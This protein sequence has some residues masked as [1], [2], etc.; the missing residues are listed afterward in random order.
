MLWPRSMLCLEM[1]QICIWSWQLRRHNSRYPIWSI[2]WHKQPSGWCMVFTLLVSANYFHNFP[3][4]IQYFGIHMEIRM[5]ITSSK[6]HSTI[7][8]KWG[9]HIL[10]NKTPILYRMA[11]CPDKH[12]FQYFLPLG[13]TLWHGFGPQ[14][15]SGRLLDGSLE[16]AFCFPDKQRQT[17]L[18]AFLAVII[19][20]LPLSFCL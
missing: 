2:V 7:I 10:V 16:Q 11:M 12:F 4:I 3:F 19:S 20:P 14:D 13:L 6:Y 1:G 15:T 9:G 5:D 17:W 8:G 18:T